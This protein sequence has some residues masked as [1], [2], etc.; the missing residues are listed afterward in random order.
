M[1]NYQ[2]VNNN[3][4]LAPKPVD[5]PTFVSGS[6]EASISRS[7]FSRH[8]RIEM[9]E[10]GITKPHVPII[11]KPMR[12]SWKTFPPAHEYLQISLNLY[13]LVVYKII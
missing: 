10:F 7:S 5:S 13:I 11:E 6:R 3:L 4:N 8:E 9:S 1:L 12:N 2:G